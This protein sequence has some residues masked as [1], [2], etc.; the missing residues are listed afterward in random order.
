MTVQTSF[1]SFSNSPSCSRIGATN[2]FRAPCPRHGKRRSR[3]KRQTTTSQGLELR[4]F[5]L[6]FA[7]RILGGENAPAN[8]TSQR[9]NSGRSVEAAGTRVTLVQRE[10]TDDE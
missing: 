5:L 7:R 3:V 10:T 8:S 2:T 9:H 1:P 4:P 6:R